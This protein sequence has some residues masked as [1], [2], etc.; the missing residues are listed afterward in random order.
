M[1]RA[2]PSKAVCSFGTC[3]MLCWLKILSFILCLFFFPNKSQ[4]FQ[5]VKNFVMR[6]WC[7]EFILILLIYVI[8]IDVIVIVI[9]V[10]VTS[11]YEHFTLCC[12]YISIILSLTHDS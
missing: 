9:I 5:I 3:W 10:G 4:R 12:S 1:R 2:S 8:V 11:C 7:F 6:A